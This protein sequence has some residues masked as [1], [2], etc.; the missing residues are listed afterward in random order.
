MAKI[1]SGNFL[2][3]LCKDDME[4]LVVGYGKRYDK[5]IFSSYL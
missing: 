4:A 5:M 2:R 3:F 1:R